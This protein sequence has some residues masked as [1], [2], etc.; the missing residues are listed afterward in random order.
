[1]LTFKDSPDF[2][3]PMDGDEDL[4]MPLAIRATGDNVYKVTVMASGGEQ[5]V[6]VTVTN[7]DEAGSDIRPAPA[8]G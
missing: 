4:M 5:E 3:D 8:A 7:V 2:E 6:A 1:M